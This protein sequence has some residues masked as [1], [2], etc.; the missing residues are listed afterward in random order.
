MSRR[1][2]TT[3]DR[4]VCLQSTDELISTTDLRGVIT[5]VNPAFAEI[6]GFSEAELLGHSH[7]MV[8]HPDM[9]KAAFA[10]MWQCL[11]AGS[12]WRGLVKNRCKDGGFYWVDAFVS[13]IFEQG[14]IIGYQSVRVKPSQ[15]TIKRAIKVYSRLN[16]GK[17]VK[18]P[19]TLTQKRL[20]SALMAGSGLLLSGYIWGWGV[21]LAGAMLMALNLAIF[22]DEA[23]RIPARLMA[24]KQEYDS[25]S[26]FI[27]AGHDTSSVLEF[28]LQRKAAMLQGVLGRTQD[29]ALK[30]NDIAAQLVV[31]TEQARV[32]MDLE[33]QQMQQ[34]ASA[35]EELHA[36]ISEVADNTQATSGR[37]DEAYGLCRQS[38]D[39]M[40]QNSEHIL[41][42]AD[43]VARAA[44]NAKR[45]NDEAQ[46]VANAMSEIDA[47]ADQTNLLAL[48]AAIEAARAGEQG[49][50]FAVVADEVRALSG[51][52]QQSTKSISASIEAMFSMLTQWAN[53]ME[54]SRQQ[55]QECATEALS[56]VDSINTV[57]Q[58]MAEIHDLARQNAVAA[59][60]QG[61]VVQ[62]IAGGI[63]TIHGATNDNVSALCQVEQAVLQLKASADRS[64]N[65]RQTFG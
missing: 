6:S 49:R 31:A 48:N 27:Y 8:R 60:Q 46:Q 53:E 12:S 18:D 52:T 14:K 33:Q 54:A 32:G 62:E 58:G 7:N 16:Q 43:D 25:V 50:G 59:T 22:Y 63:Q 57:N 5:Y 30:T 9:P 45:L 4:E 10:E 36:T 44:S 64:L 24:L 26:R 19:L 1:N 55:A 35:I 39:V 42:L 20:L 34:I 21:V 41:H 13:P 2:S 40:H 11:K 56:A 15:G 51:R 65:L 61:Q 23:F 29:Q 37:I 38:R 28:Q 47:I 3:T 17:R